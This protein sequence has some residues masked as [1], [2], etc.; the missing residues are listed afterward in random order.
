MTMKDFLRTW[1]AL[2]LVTAPALWA[3]PAP[4]DPPTG[5]QPPATR[6]EIDAWIS[7]LADDRPEE[8]DAAAAH[9]RKAGTNAI[10]ILRQA[11]AES[12]D[13]EVRARLHGILSEVDLPDLSAF[14]DVRRKRLQEDP[15]RIQATID[16]ALRWLARHQNVD[17][18]WSADHFDGH[19]VGKTCSGGGEPEYDGG[20]T[21]LALLSFLGAGFTPDSTAEIPDPADPKH[22]V[23]PGAVVRTGLKWLLSKQDAEGCIGERGSK[24]M[25]THAISTL[26]LAEAI[27]M[28]RW[29]FLRGPAQKAV[30]FLVAS[31]NPNRGWR[32]STQC[33][34]NDT[35]V[36]G[37]A[38]Q[39]L[40]AAKLAS[41]KFPPKTLVGAMAWIDEVSE[42]NAY[43][44]VGYNARNTGKL[45]TPGRN[46][47]F[48]HHATMSAIA[49]VARIFIEKRVPAPVMAQAMF[50]HADP[51]EWGENKIDSYYWYW[52]ALALFQ[53]EGPQGRSW[54]MWKEALIRALPAHQKG[55]GDGCES[56][57]WDPAMDRWG[58][59]GGRVY[60]TALNALT[61]ETPRRYP[62]VAAMKWP[63]GR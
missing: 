26:V 44:Q 17:G 55:A 47:Q 20:V 40:V 1:G 28:T 34:D 33:G 30:D 18:S 35:S 36:T 3:A 53:L 29:E 7:Q 38:A 19:C 31:Q 46:E 9:L 32:Y 24:Y 58:A 42:P 27:A 43:F 57:S 62:V 45:S 63:A 8:R 5:K 39:A 56:G 41:L 59:D 16:A 51:P 12:K 49:A 60:V 54:Q 11:L 50:L 14:F 6:A 61:L 13:P 15:D 21:A 4:Q 23:K 48:D 52:G 25:Y 2:V 10:P 22:G 37:W